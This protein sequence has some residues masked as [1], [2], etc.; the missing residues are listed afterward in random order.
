ME[1]RADDMM[2][3]KVSAAKAALYA[4]K[5]ML[6]LYD[7]PAIAQAYALLCAAYYALDDMD[8]APES[9][10]TE[11]VVEEPVALVPDDAQ[12]YAPMRAA[13]D[14]PNVRALALDELRRT[15]S[16]A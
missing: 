1:Q 3:N 10:D 13:S 7:D 5:M 4:A 11:D 9:D 8:E 12:E 2:A 14:R 6:A 16:R 15:I